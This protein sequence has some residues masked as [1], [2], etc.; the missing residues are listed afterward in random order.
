MQSQ[1]PVSFLPGQGKSHGSTERAAPASFWGSAARKARRVERSRV[2]PASGVGALDVPAEDSRSQRN[3]ARGISAPHANLGLVKGLF[4][5]PSP[6]LG[7][8]PP[9]HSSQSPNPSCQTWTE[10]AGWRRLGAAWATRTRFLLDS[11]RHNCAEARGPN[12]SWV[13]G[14]Q[15]GHTSQLPADTNQGSSVCT[16]RALVIHTS[17]DFGP[18]LLSGPPSR[19]RSGCKIQALF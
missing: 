18:G 14:P 17:W 6:P 2:V 16:G 19:W 11:N 3:G 4:V 5:T 12:P 8:V 1:E 13:L 10:S 15:L 7:S 9:S